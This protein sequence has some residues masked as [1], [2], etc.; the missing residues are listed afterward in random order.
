MRY[1]L[2]P[3]HSVDG[4]T[5]QVVVPTVADGRV[6][7]HTNSDR[8]RIGEVQRCQLLLTL[9][10]RSGAVLGPIE[11]GTEGVAHGL[12]DAPP[13]ELDLLTNESVVK[14][15]GFTHLIRMQV[16]L[17]CG[18]LDIGEQQGHLRAGSSPDPPSSLTPS[19][20]PLGASDV[21]VTAASSGS[22]RRMASSR[23]WSSGEGSRPS[24]SDNSSRPSR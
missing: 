21:G 20:T 22:W 16:P 15:Q 19:I 2:E 18:V 14:D 1:P 13:G 5:E 24:S 4:R 9:D 7:G 6:Q 10:R 12:E 23:A 3:C 11:L 8:D 17:A